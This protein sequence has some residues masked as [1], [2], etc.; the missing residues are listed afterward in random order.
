MGLF[1]CV[2]TWAQVNIHAVEESAYLMWHQEHFTQLQ[3]SIGNYF[4]EL[5]LCPILKKG[6]TE[7]YVQENPAEMRITDANHYITIMPVLLCQK[8]TELFALLFVQQQVDPYI[9]SPL[10]L[11]TCDSGE[12]MPSVRLYLDVMK[13]S[14]MRRRDLPNPNQL[15]IKTLKT[16]KNGSYK[17]E[18]MFYNA[19]KNHKVKLLFTPDSNGETD[20]EF[21]K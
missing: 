11:Y 15:H 8:K 21:L 16:Y 3:E 1:I 12:H 10:L 4:S 19:K 9:A 14:A 18:W 2:L 5:S 7:L 17:Q 6:A 20:F 13:H